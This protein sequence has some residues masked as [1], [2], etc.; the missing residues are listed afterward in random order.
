MP[1][2]EHMKKSNP[3]KRTPKDGRLFTLD[4]SLISG[5]VTEEFVRKN[6]EVC[7]TIAIRGDQTLEDLHYAIFDAFNREDEHMYE[8]QFGKRPHDRNARTYVHEFALEGPFGEETEHEGLVHDTS[9]GSLNLKPRQEFF[10]WFDFGDDWWHK[11]AVVS[12]EEAAPAGKYPRVTKSVGD[13]PPQY[14]GWDEDED[15]DE[16][17][18]DDE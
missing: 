6:K 11:I 15:E 14:I 2:D 13:S 8:F 7:R 4:V 9:I 17:D 3:K 12:I 10:Y 16:E 18:G 1:G 5:P